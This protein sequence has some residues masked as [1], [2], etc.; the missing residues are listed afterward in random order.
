[1]IMLSACGAM[2]GLECKPK[3]QAAGGGQRPPAMVTVV[4]AAGASVPVY[5]DEIGKTVSTELVSIVPQVGGKIIAAHVDH[6]AFVEKGQLLFEIDPRPFEAAL[7]AAKATLAQ[8]KAERDWA[9]I[10]LNRVEDLLSKQSA[11]QFEVDRNR[12]GLAV[13]EAKIEA[14]EAS[15]QSA[16]LDLEYSRIFAPISGRAG[17]RLVDPGNVVRANDSPLLVIQQLDPIYVEFT[18]NENDLVAVRKY[19]ATSRAGDSGESAGLRVEVEV[20][21]GRPSP[22]A[23]AGVGGAASPPGAGNTPGGPVAA[24]ASAT[25]PESASAPASAPSGPPPMAREG[26]LTFIDNSVQAGAGT[27]KL[28]ATVPNADRYLWPGQFVNVRLILEVRED[29]VL[30]PARAQQVGQIGPF[31][32]VVD[33]HHVANIRPLTLGQRHGEMI[34]VNAGLTAGEQ[35]ILTGQNMVVPGGPV[36]VVVPG[37]PPAGPAPATASAGH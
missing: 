7:A 20:P 9:Q 30:I 15:V 24:T 17:V 14:A 31:V 12:V 21:T 13:A 33:A 8:S 34:A 10:E 18:V 36:M 28:R 4:A 11:T 16:M 29:A 23:A 32:Y 3:Q 26:I 19:L 27:V 35:V 1:M 6:G 5:L 22:G 25:Q 2:L 37:A